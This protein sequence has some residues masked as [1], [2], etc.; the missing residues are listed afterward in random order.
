M[1]S[2]A[3]E[4]ESGRV[5]DT[6]LNAKPASDGPDTSTETLT[7]DKQARP[8]TPSIQPP[9]IQE[10]ATAKALQSLQGAATAPTVAAVDA[11]W[12]RTTVLSMTPSP[13]SADGDV[14]DSRV[15]RE[16]RPAQAEQAGFETDSQLPPGESEVA[17]AA[18]FKVA[19]DAVVNP[20]VVKEAQP[21]Q[22]TLTESESTAPLREAEFTSTTAPFTVATDEV[23]NP[24]GVSEVVPIRTTS[25]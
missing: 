4:N 25:D 6:D 9:S 12:E 16:T 7:A 21:L 8:N 19:S 2:L 17:I 14:V 3:D 24:W 22:A 10:D 13:N 11:G 23:T 15:M 1:D 18:P 20:W 5:L